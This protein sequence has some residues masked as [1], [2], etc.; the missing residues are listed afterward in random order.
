MSRGSNPSVHQFC[1]MASNGRAARPGGGVLSAVAVEVTTAVHTGQ[2]EVGW[3]PESGFGLGSNAI[4]EPIGMYRYDSIGSYRHG[5]ACRTRGWANPA[6]ALLS[7][8]K[9]QRSNVTA[10]MV[11]A[12]DA[13]AASAAAIAE[14][15]M[16]GCRTG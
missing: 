16:A 5:G 15:P 12:V 14:R 11:S 4:R 9:V 8:L 6:R 10:D 7:I 13:F 1:W 2:I 3:L